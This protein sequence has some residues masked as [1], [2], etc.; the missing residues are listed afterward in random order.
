M[1]VGQDGGR[2]SSSSDHPLPQPRRC[3]SEAENRAIKDLLKRNL[4]EIE[5]VDAAEADA[6]KPPGPGGTLLRTIH[7]LTHWLSNG[8]CDKKTCD[9][10]FIYLKVSGAGDGL[11]RT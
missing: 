1:L 8:E 10:F 6:G 7:T 5:F 9:N 11:R 3:H 2:L 4:Q